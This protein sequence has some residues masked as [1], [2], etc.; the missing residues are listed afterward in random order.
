MITQISLLL[1]LSLSST[2]ATNSS[3][4]AIGAAYTCTLT[5]PP[6]SSTGGNPSAIV[7]S[8]G[9]PHPN[10]NVI[11][12]VSFTTA[13]LLLSI[14]NGLLA[15]LASNRTLAVLWLRPHVL[16]FFP[17][18][19]IAIISISVGESDR[20]SQLPLPIPAFRN[21][22][23]A[24]RG[25]G[26]RL[27]TVSTAAFPPSP[28]AFEEPIGEELIRP[29]LLQFLEET[30]STLL[31][32]LDLNNKFRLG[33]A[34]FLKGANGDDFATG[35]QHMDAVPTLS[36]APGR[37]NIPWVVGE[38][39]WP[40]SDADIAAYSGA[41]P[42]KYA[43]WYLKSLV[44]HLIL[45]HGTPL[46]REGL[47]EDYIYKLVEGDPEEDNWGLI[48][49]HDTHSSS[50]SSA[51]S[52]FTFTFLL[53][54]V[55][56]LLVPLRKASLFD[57]VTFPP[58]ILAGMLYGLARQVAAKV[59]KHR[60]L[61][62]LATMLTAII[63]LFLAQHFLGLF[64]LVTI[65]FPHFRVE[66]SPAAFNVILSFALMFLLMTVVFLMVLEKV[67]AIKPRPLQTIC[68]IAVAALLTLWYFGHLPL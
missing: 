47:A 48:Y 57:N 4:A 63:W 39:G 37:G 17:R 11:R 18:C 7:A 16:P 44:A 35:V 26:I 3:T 56:T 15:P 20:V 34:L 52:T 25:I 33:W 68:L 54:I 46:G 14:P 60:V 1:L 42:G 24:L 12:A 19:K 21:I 51:C 22:L 38:T 30:N 27:I 31:E 65:F 50:A 36:A 5:S 67:V 61:F 32:I 55:F 2:G 8:A 9:L 43:E 29:L 64:T 66:S 41:N 6:S 10:P 62:S 49:P 58:V 23:I 45:A 13:S 59:R 28:A 40:I 53:V